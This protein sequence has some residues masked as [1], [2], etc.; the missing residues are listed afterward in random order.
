MLIFRRKLN[1]EIVIGDNEIVISLV[2]IRGNDVKIGVD[3]PKSVTIHR[4]EVLDAIKREGSSD[5][6]IRPYKTE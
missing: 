6:Y 2:E 3:A 1:E 5:R 4:R